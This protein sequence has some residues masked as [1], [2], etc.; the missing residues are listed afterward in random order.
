M[1]FRPNT[2]PLAE[3]ANKMPYQL[4]VT[5]PVNEDI[6]TEDVRDLE[7]P[8]V[9]FRLRLGD[10]IC[11]SSAPPGDPRIPQ[12]SALPIPGLSYGFTHRNS[13]EIDSSDD[14]F[15]PPH[16]P[17]AT[18]IVDTFA[19]FTETTSNKRRRRLKSESQPRDP[20]SRRLFTAEDY[21]N[22]PSQP[23]IDFDEEPSR[24]GNQVWEGSPT[25]KP[26]RMRTGMEVKPVD[27]QRERERLGDN[28]GYG[29]PSSEV[30]SP[31]PL[32]PGYGTRYSV[33]TP[34]GPGSNM[35]S[36]PQLLPPYHPA[37][38]YSS[39]PYSSGPPSVR[40]VDASGAVRDVQLYYVPTPQIF[41]QYP[42]G[43]IPRSAPAQPG[44]AP[45]AQPH[46]APPSGPLMAPPSHHAPAPQHGTAP[47]MVY[48]GL[49]APFGAGFAINSQGPSSG[50]EFGNYYT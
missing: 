30:D 37:S 21:A 50:P 47:R 39:G 48:R 46:M 28:S 4:A 12:G 45:P 9:P 8:Q 25:H 19:P 18:N 22:Y 16:K 24:S 27:H 29:Q 36:H 20:V 32:P 44:L 41:D 5:K 34:F 38:T 15:I 31:Y 26:F 14:L 23:R 1:A 6:D 42:V 7:R 43:S 17:A 10:Q 35:H 13:R 11:P 2:L 33:P 40:M 49:R 3:G